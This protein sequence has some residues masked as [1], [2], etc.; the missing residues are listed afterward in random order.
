MGKRRFYMVVDEEQYR[1]FNDIFKLVKKQDE[2][3]TKGDLFAVML[4][5]WISITKNLYNKVNEENKEK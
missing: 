4:H 3:I 2:T 1:L 5:Y